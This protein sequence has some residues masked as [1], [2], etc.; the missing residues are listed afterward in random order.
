MQGSKTLVGLNTTRLPRTGFYTVKAM[1]FITEE[2]DIRLTSGLI[3][4]WAELVL[5]IVYGH[6]ENCSVFDFSKNFMT[7][8]HC[9]LPI[10]MQ[11]Q[12]FVPITFPNTFSSKL[13]INTIIFKVDVICGVESL[14]VY[15]LKMKPNFK[16]ILYRYVIRVKNAIFPSPL[17]LCCLC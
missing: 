10:F 7:N 9:L 16:C 15:F 14:L 2:K 3:L 6:V 12:K 8:H 4:V 13:R 5:L 11:K 1:Q 17:R